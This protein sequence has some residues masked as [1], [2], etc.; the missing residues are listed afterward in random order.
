MTTLLPGVSL[1]ASTANAEHPIYLRVGEGTSSVYTITGGGDSRIPPPVDFSDAS[2]PP[3]WHRELFA[4]F[5]HYDRQPGYRITPI[6][7][8]GV[9]IGLFAPV[10]PSVNVDMPFGF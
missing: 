9:E 10:N 4:E 7:H 2:D 5:L 1:Q 8:S 3:Y 6:V